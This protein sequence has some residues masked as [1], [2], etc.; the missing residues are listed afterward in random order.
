[1]RSVRKPP[2]WL[3]WIMAAC[4]SGPVL[5]TA[6]PGERLPVEAFARLPVLDGIE[7]SPGGRHAAAKLLDGEARYGVV[8]F[9]LERLGKQPPLRASTGEWDVNWLRWK[10]D[11]RLLVSGRYTFFDGNFGIAQTRLIAVDADGSD[12]QWLLRPRP[13]QKGRG[14][15][16]VQFRDRIVDLLPADPQHVLLAMN[17]EIESRPNLYRV[18]IGNDHR[19][20]IESG[21]SWIQSWL[22][23]QQGRV[24][25]AQGFDVEG[26]IDASYRTFHRS[27]PAADWQRIWDEDERRAEFTPVLFDSGDAD[28][29]TV[30]SDFEN[31]RR[32]LYRYRLSSNQFVDKLFLHPEVDIAEVILDPPGRQVEGV[33]YITDTQ[34][35][36]WFGGPLA[37]AYRDLQSQLPGW[38]LAIESRTQDSSLMV[39]RASA[40]DHSGRHYLY[41]PATREL[42]LFSAMYPELD[43]HDLARVVPVRYRARDGLEIPAYLTLPRGV[44]QPPPRPLPAVIM[45][46]GGPESRDYAD[47]DPV[48]Q[49]LANRG[50]AVLQMN[51]R[52]SAGYGRAFLG[53]GQRE[54][55][56]AIQDDITDG[57]RWLIDSGV[58]D[59]ARICIVGASFGGYAALMGVVE[60]PALYR[61]AV[62]LNGVSDLPDLVNL[63]G[64]YFVGARRSLVRRIGGLWADRARLAT[65][66]PARRASEI[67]APVLLLHAS[68]DEIVPPA[69][70]RK[71]ADALQAAGKASRYVPLQEEDHGLTHGPTRLQFFRELEQFLATHLR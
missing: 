6:A 59:P 1:M 14:H 54:W 66:S 60:E 69:Q 35:F 57:T 38:A 4:C 67:T 21:R 9:D 27:D 8:I 43:E 34:R 33:R 12:L 49:L 30:L 41:R 19:T 46:H 39:V 15:E 51:F 2:G 58:A 32:G 31:G 52:G 65:H 17:S 36:E 53:A 64:R 50:Y 42:R 18:N 63:R 61:C 28:L 20:K 45:P 62:S 56:D 22:L 3:P 24:R 11:D 7:L 26:G 23:D 55:G 5:V 25:L 71:M 13:A 29:V 16:F 37:A 47:F 70:S 40:A 48:V 10:S 44:R 68:D